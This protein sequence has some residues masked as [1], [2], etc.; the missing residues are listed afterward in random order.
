MTERL[1]QFKLKEIVRDDSRSALQKYRDLFTGNKGWPGFIYFEFSTL[2]ASHIP[3]ALG[4]A[5]RKLFY[6]RLFRSCESG[7]VFGHHLGLRR[8]GSMFIGKNCVIDDYVLLSSR[9]DAGRIEL[10]PN[11]FIG[12]FSQIRARDGCIEIAED[13][14]IS[15]F[16]H[17]GTA[18]KITIGKNCLFG[19][20]C[21]IGGL[22]HGTSNLDVAIIDQPLDEPKGVV[23]EEN[24]WLGAHVIV[25]DGVTI[26]QGSVVGAGSVVTKDIPAGTV[27][28]GVPARV[29]RERS[30]GS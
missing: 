8:P 6:P 3:G 26:G 29:L 21:Y 9:G 18:A 20:G 7:V 15:T 28:A 24:V 23:I 2:I 4:L 14:N 19:S 5:L 25:N 22:S 10:K 1:N 16:C 11:V 17:I 13:A 27:N 12:Q 30:A